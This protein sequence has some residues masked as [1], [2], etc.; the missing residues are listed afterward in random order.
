MNHT[1]QDIKS[2]YD[3]NGYPFESDPFYVNLF[4]IRS[5]QMTVDLFND[6]IGLAYKD[7]FDNAICLVF[8]AS[9]KP[10]LYWLKNKLGNINGTFILKD[11]FH[12]NA[13]KKGQHSGRYDALVQAAYGNLPG[14][15]DNDAD[16]ELDMDG[17]IYHDVTG[18][19]LHTTSFINEIEK[20]GAY[21]AGCQVV[22]DDKDFEVVRA[23]AYKSM[24]IYKD[25][26]D[27]ALFQIP[28]D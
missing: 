16:G 20:V 14:W 13:F 22:A 8:R 11:G 21:S 28:S 27:Y 26:I 9:T 25:Q 7:D 23:L 2:L 5:K 4:G 24:D 3:R 17:K 1:Y 6:I 18:L 19:N 10:G 15:R 12:Q